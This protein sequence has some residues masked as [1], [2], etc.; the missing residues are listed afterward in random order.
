[1]QKANRR[2]KTGIDADEARRKREDNIIELRKSKR[3]EGLQK[4]RQTFAA[5]QYAIEDS[6]KSGSGIQQR[7]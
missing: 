2:V 5:P 7:V 3:D 4:K 6:T 1:M